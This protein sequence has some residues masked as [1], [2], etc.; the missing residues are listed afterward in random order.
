MNHDLTLGAPVQPASGLL[1][2]NATR[3]RSFLACPRRFFL[4]HVLNLVGE[5]LDSDASVLGHAV[6]RELYE[7][8]RL[9]ER[10]DNDGVVADDVPIDSFVTSRVLAHQDLCPAT[11]GATYLGG[12]VDLRWLLRSK[13][14]LVTGRADALWLDADETLELRDY[15]TGH[16]PESLEEDFPAQLYLILAATHPLRPSKVRVVYEQLGPEPRTVALE[17]SEPRITAAI[18]AL[19]DLADRIRQERDFQATPSELNCSRCSFGSVCPVSM[20]TR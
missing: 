2:L 8:H 10:H 12:E 18:R 1:V 3:I 14:L 11:K 20:E 6:H 5:E 17:G 16:C 19:R 13:N 9:F 15:K 7:R 4:A